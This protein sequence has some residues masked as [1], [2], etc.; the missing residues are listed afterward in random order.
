M[1]SAPDSPPPAALA[2]RPEAKV[3]SVD[4]LLAEVIAGRVRIPKF[5]RPLRWD[6]KDVLELLDSVHRGYPIG[7][8]LFW[9]RRAEA[10]HIVHGSVSIEAP[11]VTDALW[12]VDGQQRIVSLTRAIHGVGFP[13]EPFAAFFD[14]QERRFVRPPRREPVPPHY[15]P[16]TEVLDS[17]RLLRWLRKSQL[18]EELESR[19]FEVGKLREYQI[20]AYVVTADDERSVREIFRRANNSGKR[21]DDSDVFNALYSAGGTPAS[22]RDV[23][24]RLASLKFGGL[25]EPTLL[26]MLQSLL[27]SDLSKDRVPELSQQEASDAMA[28]LTRSARDVLLFLQEDVGIPHVSLLPYQQP[29]FALA[30][31]FHRHPRPHPRS[32][33]LLARWLWRGA[34]SGAHN[35]NALST[36]EMLAAIGEDE[37]GSVQS[38]LKT[39]P[40]RPG[41]PMALDNFAFNYARCKIQVLAL[42]SLAPVDLRTGEPVLAGDPEVAEEAGSGG[43]GATGASEG[44]G[45]KGLIRSIC[46]H[47]AARGSSLANRMIHPGVRSG[48]VRLISTCEDPVWLATHGI[49]R[50][51][52]GVLLRGDDVGFLVEREAGLARLLEEFTEA[53]AQWDE[54]DYPPVESLRIGND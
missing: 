47:P 16:L 44:G 4:R 36:R 12:V 34:I 50:G 28:S 29:L 40:P 35:G 39:L 37:H 48:L 41:E 11:V 21:M 52:R 27:G 46:P 25:D 49:S 9:R 31:F 14:L 30:R 5:Q 54:V 20:P 32:R 7:T 43:E 33:E 45:I 53:R 13:E 42:L 18:S 22:L 38:L 15:L 19:A 26:R 10:D 24:A 23:S 2:G 8:L 51:A 17:G 3:Y 1:A 6:S